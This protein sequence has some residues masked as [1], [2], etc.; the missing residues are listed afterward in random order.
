MAD[1]RYGPR[2]TPPA[3]SLWWAFS[4]R[5]TGKPGS[6]TFHCPRCGAAGVLELETDEIPPIAGPP[7]P[8]RISCTVCALMGVVM[9][10][11][12]AAT[13]PPSSFLRAGITSPP[14][15]ADEAQ[16]GG[17]ADG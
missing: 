3:I 13:R 7:A 4:L 12:P 6:I 8:V 1:R 5:C 16:E 2:P 9:L 11:P 14:P 10:E 15:V 17:Q